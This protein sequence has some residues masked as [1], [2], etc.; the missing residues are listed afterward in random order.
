MWPGLLALFGIILLAFAAFGVKAGRV[1]L[2]LLAAAF[3]SAA[4]TWP[5][6]TQIGG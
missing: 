3:L 6:L 5:Y 1:S 2:P 4:A